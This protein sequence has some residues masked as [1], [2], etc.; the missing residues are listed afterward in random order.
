MSHERRAIM[1]AACE[2]LLTGE[3]PLL[4]TGSGSGSRV[5]PAQL[6]QYGTHRPV[7]ALFFPTGMSQLEVAS[8]EACRVGQ[9]APALTGGSKSDRL[10]ADGNR[11]V[12]PAL[13][14][15]NRRAN[16]E[17]DE[18]GDGHRPLLVEREYVRAQ[19]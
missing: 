7:N 13:L 14:E 15:A 8:R 16:E 12:D 5:R 18:D 11:I 3:E 4:L 6:E 10:D 19:G 9:A 1:D 2:D 17:D